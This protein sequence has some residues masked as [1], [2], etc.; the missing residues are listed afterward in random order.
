MSS[1]KN[2]S[3]PAFLIT[4]SN[5]PDG[6]ACSVFAQQKYPDLITIFALHNNINEIIL[7]VVKQLDRG[8]V[9][10]IADIICDEDVLTDVCMELIKANVFIGVY[11]H[12]KSRD[13]LQHYKL[14]SGIKGEVIFDN[15][16]CGSKILFDAL[17]EEKVEGLENFSDFSTVINDRDLWL[18][19]D[20]RGI[21]MAKL[22][23][24]Y[25]D[26]AFVNRF[27]KNSKAEFTKEE[28]VLISFVSKQ[29]SDR[30]KKELDRIVLKTDNQGFKF[31]V[32]YCS[33]ESSDL[34]N[35]AIERFEL[36]Y[37]IML[38]LNRSKGSIRGKGNMDCS[39]YA[40]NKGGGG[41]RCASG[42]PVNV[43]KPEL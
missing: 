16:R 22:H 39:E 21:L 34:L 18:N 25:G 37:A 30:I 17:L 35:A 2:K 4:H 3:L 6:S 31:G 23:H 29:E 1:N 14:P 8:G 12:H 27:L 42:F 15:S 43:K 10:I 41:H 5:C 28:T 19:K 36:E 33:G 7:D 13:W 38:D 26:T 9:L 11:E 20:D 32:I 24:I 40:S